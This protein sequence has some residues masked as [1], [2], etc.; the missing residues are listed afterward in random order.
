M[1]HSVAIPQKTKSRVFF[2]ITSAT[3]EVYIYIHIYMC[4]YIYIYIY[5]ERERERERE[6]ETSIY[7]YIPESFYCTPET[8]TTL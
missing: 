1:Q 4:I 2:F 8:N 5:I 7:L 3:W 6:K